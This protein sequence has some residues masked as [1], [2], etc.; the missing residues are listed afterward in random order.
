ME[1]LKIKLWICGLFERECSEWRDIILIKE[2]LHQIRCSVSLNLTMKELLVL[3]VG[4]C[5][6]W[7]LGK[8]KPCMSVMYSIFLILYITLIRRTPGYTEP[9]RFYA[10][11]W[12]ETGFWAGGILN[13]LLYVPFGYTDYI[14]IKTKKKQHVMKSII[15][16]GACLS[17]LCELIQ[18]ITE[19]GWADVN[20]V[21]F[22]VIGGVLGSIIVVCRVYWSKD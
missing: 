22:N 16:T 4:A 18:Y 13:I 11:E 9:V 14:Y 15:L 3:T 6:A 17:I 5:V 10:G 1:K 7:K 12:K 8:K 21:L 2:M 19:R 20:D